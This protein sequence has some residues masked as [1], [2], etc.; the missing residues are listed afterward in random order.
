MN[1]K[2]IRLVLVFIL[3]GAAGASVLAGSSSDLLGNWEATVEL[4]KFKVRLV[5][6][7][8][9]SADRK[10]SGK[11]DIP[12]QGAK[13]I[14]ISAILCNY[15]AVRWELDPFDNT[16]FN[17]NLSSD[18]NQIAGE[19]EEGPGGRPLA[20]VFKR[21]TTS[22]DGPTLTYTFAA[23]ES[24][25]IRGYWQATL[26]QP[27]E[28]SSRIGLRI[29]RAP[30][31]SFDALMDALDRGMMDVKASSAKATSSSARLEWQLMQFS[32]DGKLDPEGNKLIGTWE[33]RGKPVPVT[34]ERLD[35]PAT[36]LP[37]NVSFE[38]DKG[39]PGDIRG[40]WKGS[41]ELPDHNSLR[42]IIR[43]GKT[44][45]G[46]FAGLLASPDQGGGQLPM[47]SGSLSNA[48]VK[49]EWK[50]IRGTFKGSLNS[51]GTV[52]DGNWEQM[53]PPLKLKLERSSASQ[54]AVKP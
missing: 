23:G 15:P 39:T 53:G 10:L 44:P 3:G 48:V 50:S 40:E 41:I 31:G 38:P 45:D 8:A 28:I 22:P 49:L 5:A 33:Q 13:D 24:K 32:F 21:L 36:V 25:D 18:G 43:I 16:A 26:E 12:D 54:P 34:F 19:F 51:E 30:D 17:G 52:L 47:T 7:V 46:A 27:Q 20:V 4:G 35:Q 2:L 11:I 9:Q 1:T 42:I 37:P 29:G 6:R 14:P